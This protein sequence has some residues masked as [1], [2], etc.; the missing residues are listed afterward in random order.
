M[1]FLEMYHGFK[2]NFKEKIW[3]WNLEKKG[4]TL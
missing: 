3:N 1:L 4:K 2:R